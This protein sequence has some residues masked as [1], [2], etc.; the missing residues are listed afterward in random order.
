MMRPRHWGQQP[1]AARHTSTRSR[2]RWTCGEHNAQ[3]HVSNNTPLCSSIAHECGM[4]IKADGMT[5]VTM[6]GSAPQ[7]ICATRHACL[8][9]S[10][11]CVSAANTMAWV[12][13]CGLFTWCIS[14]CLQVL[15]R[16]VTHQHWLQRRTHGSW[17][18]STPS[19]R[20]APCPGSCPTSSYALLGGAHVPGPQLIVTPAH[21]LT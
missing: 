15:L 19:N 11:V 9:S 16:G 6:C 13:V 1:A 5:H 12:S 4:A 14:R 18:Q 8:L 3:Q 10:W 17:R 7:N 21:N 2:D 20:W